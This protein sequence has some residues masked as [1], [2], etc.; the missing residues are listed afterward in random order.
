[1]PT[2]NARKHT[3]PAGSDKSFNRATIFEAF[4]NSI[5][6]V[7]PV[8]NATERAQLV[9]ALSAKGAGP[10]ASTPLIVIRADAPGMSRAE[11]SADGTTWIPLSGVL[12]FPNKTAADTFGAS[13]GGLLATGDEAMIGG[14]RHRWSGTLWYQPVVAGRVSTNTGGTSQDAGIV[15]VTHGMG[16]AP[17]AVT[18]VVGMDSPVIPEALKVE[19]GNITATTFDVRVRRADQGNAPFAGNPVVF[20]W[21]AVA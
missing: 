17:T 14:V 20:Y 9:S 4:G 21:T 11:W 2:T 10:T 5:H 18:A 1:M 7:I 13:S 15:K 6:D 16:K 3:I 12:T 8:T 19:V